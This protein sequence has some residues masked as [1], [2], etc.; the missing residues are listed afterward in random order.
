LTPALQE[1]RVWDVVPHTLV[2]ALVQRIEGGLRNYSRGYLK[3]SMAYSFSDPPRN[4]V[5]V[6]MRWPDTGS[7][8]WMA[9]ARP[10]PLEGAA[11]GVQRG[12]GGGPE[13]GNKQEA[14]KVAESVLLMKFYQLSSTAARMLVTAG[15]GSTLQELPFKLSAQ[16]EAVVKLPHR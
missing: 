1:I 7:F 16:E 11:E 2:Q 4:R 5:R 8:Q 14:A 10:R 3:R 15:A 9:A 6:P 12:P 13:G